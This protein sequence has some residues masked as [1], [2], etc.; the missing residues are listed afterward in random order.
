MVGVKL[1]FILMMGICESVVMLVKYGIVLAGVANEEGWEKFFYS[2]GGR[3]VAERGL[4]I[5]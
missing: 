1:F 4:V 3:V 5:Y 2:Y